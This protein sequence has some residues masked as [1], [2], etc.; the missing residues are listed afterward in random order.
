[1]DFWNC[2]LILHI[3]TWRRSILPFRHLR[4]Y[5]WYTCWVKPFSFK[6]SWEGCWNFGKEWGIHPELPASCAPSEGEAL[7]LLFEDGGKKASDWN[8]KNQVFKPICTIYSFERLSSG[9]DISHQ[10]SQ[11]MTYRS[12]H[13]LP[14]MFNMQ[15]K[16]KVNKEYGHKLSN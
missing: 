4:R 7:E 12:T 11:L 13:E 8:I 15:A 1:M 2:I 10:N 9:K 3:V 5:L 16:P 6:S 14:F